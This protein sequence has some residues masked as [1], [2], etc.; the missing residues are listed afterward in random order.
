M[1]V[2]K[3]ALMQ[4]YNLTT[5]RLS[6]FALVSKSEKKKTTKANCEQIQNKFIRFCLQLDNNWDK[7]TRTNKLV[8]YF[9]KI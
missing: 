7:R 2:S 3:K 5:F 1:T 6:L 8:P 4:Y 9:R